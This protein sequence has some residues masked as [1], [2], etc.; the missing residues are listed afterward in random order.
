VS[1]AYL[2][3]A[4]PVDRPAARR[5]SPLI[6]RRPSLAWALAAPTLLAAALIAGWPLVRTIWLSLTDATLAQPDGAAFVGFANYAALLAD[7]EWW[8]STANTLLLTALAV[9]LE[10]C[11]GLGIALVLAARFP[12]RA[13]LRAAV[14]VPWAIPTVV[15]AKMWG[16]MLHDL[17]GVINEMLIALGLIA[18]PIAW[19][20]E[21][22]L[23]LFV[24]VAVDVWKTTPFV[25]LLVLAALE[26]IPRQLYDAARVDGAG[27]VVTF[28]RIT[29][30]LI[31]PALLVA[32]VFRTLDT[33]RVFDI[34][35]VLTG[36]TADTMTMAIFVRQQLV[37]FQDVGYGSAAATLVFFIIA[38]VT[39]IYLTVARVRLEVVR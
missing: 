21:R 35:Y 39:A 30:P 6:W 27:P 19:T 12:G 14:L 18:A 8:R 28:W 2:E 24:V 4:A 7:P 31:R 36:T 9:T 34:V 33:L 25:A 10:A 5:A 22:D 16:W 29:L 17:Y 32:V 3:A 38:V 20:A 26:M 23:A 1:G 37:D 13:L 15:S 11:L